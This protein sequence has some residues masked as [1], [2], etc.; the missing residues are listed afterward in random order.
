MNYEWVVVGH[1]NPMGI[2]GN[3]FQLVEEL[4]QHL[5]IRL[6]HYDSNQVTIENHAVKPNVVVVVEYRAKTE[7]GN[8]LIRRMKRD[9]VVTPYAL[10]EAQL[11]RGVWIKWIENGCD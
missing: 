8:E 1:V 5:D 4:K 11:P 2:R 7:T 10:K 9:F 6:S 3:A